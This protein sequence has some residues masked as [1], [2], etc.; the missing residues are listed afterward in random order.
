MVHIALDLGRGLE[1][2]RFCAND[3]RDFAAHHDLLARNHA[4]DFATFADDNLD[5]LHIAFDLT[6]NL[7]EAPADD[8]EPLAHDL[9][10]VA[11]D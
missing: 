7:K 2:D 11:D 9:Q 4:G 6:V 5:G 1:G 3:A 8:F 10:I